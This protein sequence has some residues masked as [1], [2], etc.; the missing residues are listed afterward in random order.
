MPLPEQDAGRDPGF[1]DSQ[2][3]E[4]QADGEGSDRGELQGRC[5]SYNLDRA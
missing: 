5:N 2:R 4:P 1:P 3:A